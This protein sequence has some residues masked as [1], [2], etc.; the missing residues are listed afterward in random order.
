MIHNQ[1]DRAYRPIRESGRTPAGGYATRADDRGSELVVRQISLYRASL[2]AE[3]I[4]AIE[5][6]IIESAATTVDG[7]TL[8]VFRHHNPTGGILL[9][10]RSVTPGSC[11]PGGE[12]AEWFDSLRPLF[13]EPIASSLQRVMKEPAAAALRPLVA[14]KRLKVWR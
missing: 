3:D 8:K 5:K 6:S 2:T 4:P 7:V 13:D 9:A 1:H 14:P 11:T 12:L 10:E